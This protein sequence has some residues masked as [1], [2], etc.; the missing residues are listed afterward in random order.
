MDVDFSKIF[1]V[2]ECVFCDKPVAIDDLALRK[3]YECEHPKVKIRE[4]SI[5]KKVVVN[6]YVFNLSIAKMNILWQLLLQQYA[7]IILSRSYEN[8]LYVQQAQPIEWLSNEPV[9]FSELRAAFGVEDPCWKL[10]GGERPAEQC[11]FQFVED[12][13]FT[14]E[15]LLF[16]VFLQ[17]DHEHNAPKKRTIADLYQMSEEWSMANNEVV[18]HEE[19]DLDPS[20]TAFLESLVEA[21]PKSWDDDGMNDELCRIAEEVE[22]GVA[23]GSIK[24]NSVRDSNRKRIHW[25]GPVEDGEVCKKMI[26]ET[27]QAKLDAEKVARFE[28]M[29]KAREE[30]KALNMAAHVD[31]DEEVCQTGGALTRRQAAAATPPQPSTSE[32]LTP[33]EA[34]KPTIPVSYDCPHCKKSFSHF[35]NLSAHIKN[36]HSEWI[37]TRCDSKFETRALLDKHRRD[38]Q[39]YGLPYGNIDSNFF[40]VEIVKQFDAAHAQFILSPKELSDSLEIVFA[41]AAQLMKPVFNNFLDNF[42]PFKMNVTLYCTMFKLRDPTY[43]IHNSFSKPK[44]ESTP[45]FQTLDDVEIILERQFN[46]LTEWVEKYNKMASNWILQSI[47]KLVFDCSQINFVR[48]GAGKC[49]LPAAI[50]HSK[51]VINFEL[52]N[53]EECFVYAIA[54]AIHHKQI[55]LQA[56]RHVDRPSKYKS[57]VKQFDVSTI[58]FPVNSMQIQ[59]F[60][61]AN[62]TISIFAHQWT[63]YGHPECIYRTSF[64]GRE[65]SVHLFCHQ[66]HWL[67]ITRLTAFYR[68]GRKHYWKCEKCLK[69][70]YHKEDFEA[71]S[72]KCKGIHMVQN[73]S[74][75]NPPICSFRDH[76]KT[77]DAPTVMYADIEAILEKLDVLPTNTQRTHRHI[78][79]AIGSMIISRI[80]DNWFHEK[81]V[82]H[83]GPTCMEQFID[84][85]EEVA[86]QVWSWCEGFETRIRDKRSP[87][88]LKRFKNASYCYLCNCAFK[89]ESN[90]KNP[91]KHFDHDHLTG[92]YRGAACAHCNRKMR[93]SRRS[94]PIYFHNYR[95]YDNHHIVHAFNNRPE[96]ELEPIAQ[97]MEKFMAM[98]AKFPVAKY[99]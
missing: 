43:I 80:P 74:I 91:D 94:V 84:Y 25:D 35:C 46:N 27:E 21:P 26:S 32:E 38:C 63:T 76:D 67:P 97:N 3:H 10:W 53:S 68:Q 78:P 15:Q 18:D 85:L 44:G 41:E 30:W 19:L 22:R 37:C 77:V 65:H 8:G 11:Q 59:K 79:C 98:T 88:E 45:T 34:P 75:P 1:F 17:Q 2:R 70:Y 62:P 12:S 58:T 96:W 93:L 81:Y 73:E 20:C 40:D 31:L 47:D 51:A 90:G 71:H 6:D 56:N 9:C 54:M 29:N 60:E 99:N 24:V 95:G 39:K 83:V 89:Q 7:V 69:S 50:Q 13:N 33:V 52:L 66:E 92:K 86:M 42:K 72:K 48:G 28:R 4:C 87:D 64:S 61:K 23:D 49:I 57:F 36:K 5:C 55:A 14:Y 16:N 82:E